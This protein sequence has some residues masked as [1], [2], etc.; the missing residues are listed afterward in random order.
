MTSVA[1]IKARL[2][3]A[4]TPFVAV[5]GAT[6]LAQVKDKP[7]SGLPVAFVLVS[8]DVSAENARVAGPV[9][10]RMERDIM[11]VTVCEDRGDADGD[12]V[13]DQLEAIKTFVRGKLIG[14]LP[15]DMVAAGEPITHV[16]GEVVEAVAGCVWHQDVFS[17]PIYIEETN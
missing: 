12:A 9:L 17:A 14:F 11:V 1:E 8:K 7:A 2:L 3:G 13:I 16:A 15:T 5:K 6:A 4:G 10:Q